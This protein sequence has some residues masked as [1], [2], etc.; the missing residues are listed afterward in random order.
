MAGAGPAWLDLL[1]PSAIATF[2]VSATTRGYTGHEMLDPVGLVHMNGRVYDPELGRFLSADPFVQD[3]SN[4]QSWNRYSYVINNPL[5]L[6]DPSGFFFSGLFKN[7]WNGLK[8]MFSA[9]AACSKPC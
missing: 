3:A 5:S 7:I 1:A 9:S 4:L 2:D 6:T 8:S